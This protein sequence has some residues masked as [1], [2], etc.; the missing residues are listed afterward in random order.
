MASY[1]NLIDFNTKKYHFRMSY[2]CQ[3]RLFKLYFSKSNG[4]YKSYFLKLLKIMFTFEI[5]K[6]I[7]I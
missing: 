3:N 2:L 4:E 5:K 7:T 6:N 1:K